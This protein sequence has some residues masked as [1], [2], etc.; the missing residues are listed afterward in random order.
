MDHHIRP[1]GWDA[2]GKRISMLDGDAVIEG[3]SAYPRSGAARQR[4]ICLHTN[5]T[6][7]WMTHSQPDQQL[8]IAT[9]NIHQGIKGNRPE[10]CW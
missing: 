4:L 8:A 1:A 10:F 9:A 3:Q 2:S 6:G 7:L 5:E